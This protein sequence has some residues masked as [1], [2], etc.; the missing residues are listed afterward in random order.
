M[1]RIVEVFQNGITEVFL[2][3]ITFNVVAAT[4]LQQIRQIL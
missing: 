1:Q 2:Q 3:S 4:F